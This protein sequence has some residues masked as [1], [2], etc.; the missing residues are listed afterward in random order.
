M[1]EQ[2]LYLKDM[3]GTRWYGIADA[4]TEVTEQRFTCSEE[5]KR[6]LRELKILLAGL[7][8][9]QETGPR[10]FNGMLKN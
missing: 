8:R 10:R 7:M 9:H 1:S 5:G 2:G 3:S 6:L 4:P